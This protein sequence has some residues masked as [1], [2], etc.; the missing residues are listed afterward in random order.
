VLAVFA[1]SVPLESLTHL[2]SRAIYATRNTIL[3]TLASIAGFVATVISAQALVPRIGLAAIPAGFAIGMGLK[4]A[5]LAAALVPRIAGI[6]AVP[7]GARRPMARRA[8]SP[9]RAALRPGLVR[10][11]AI[12]L[13]IVG[14]GAGVLYAT[15]QALA[16]GATLAVDPIVTPWARVNAATPVA[17]IASS[18]VPSISSS[19]PA[20]PSGSPGATPSPG[21]SASASPSPSPTPGPFAMDLYKKGDYVAEL[22]D[23][24][25]VPAAMQTSMN[26]MDTGA[27]TSETTQSRIFSLARSIAPAPDGAAE[28]EAWAKGLAELGYGN[29]AVTERTTI[30]DAIHLAAHQVRVTNRPAGLMVW[31]GAHSWVLSGFTATA[32]PALT[33]SF[34]VTAVRIEDV[35]Y[36]RLSTI[37]GY[38]R[39]PDSLVPVNALPRDYLP[40]KRPTGLYPD[41]DGKFVVVIPTT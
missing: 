30:R 18:L 35:W 16:S 26:I 14:L 15:G 24:W 21:V 27:D 41:K 11:V 40:W 3:P 39:P 10:T 5:I 9:Q 17:S 19:P 13:T 31:R 28:P 33:D 32:D 1:I 22:K 25:C 38:S 2:L 12:S 36:P 6:G 23:V 8:G 4:V 29:Y 34:V 37:W 7:V 20:R